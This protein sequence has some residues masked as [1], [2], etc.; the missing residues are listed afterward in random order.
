MTDSIITVADERR[1]LLM[2]RRMTGLSKTFQEKVVESAA[3]H[4]AMAKEKAFR[5]TPLPDR[6]ILQVNNS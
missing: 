6:V 5:R 3:F 4:Y 1:N 2:L